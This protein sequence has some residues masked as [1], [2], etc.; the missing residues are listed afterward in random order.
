MNVEDNSE[1]TVTPILH[2]ETFINNKKNTDVYD[3]DD[4]FNEL[5]ALRKQLEEAKNN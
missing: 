1:N 2:S 5:V 3:K 4:N